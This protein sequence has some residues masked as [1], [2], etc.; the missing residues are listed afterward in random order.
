MHLILLWSGKL[1]ARWTD[2]RTEGEVN[3]FLIKSSL[4]GDREKIHYSLR[5]PQVFETNYTLL[6]TV[7]G[8]P[9]RRSV[10]N[11]SLGSGSSLSSFAKG[12]VRHHTFQKLTMGKLYTVSRYSS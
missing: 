4:W 6:L 12:G 2:I 10:E 5:D 8:G 1:E 7:G 9:N 11:I 3:T